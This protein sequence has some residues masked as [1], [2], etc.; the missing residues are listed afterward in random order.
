MQLA[1]PEAP[2]S[3][4]GGGGK[5]RTV[6]AVQHAGY[7]PARQRVLASVQVDELPDVGRQL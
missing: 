2:D 6:D 5:A 4:P 3:A 1:A 7:G